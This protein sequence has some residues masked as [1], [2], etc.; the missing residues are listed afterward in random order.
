LLGEVP[1]VGDAMTRKL[2]LMFL[3]AALCWMIPLANAGAR[4]DQD[5]KDFFG[6]VTLGLTL[7]QGDFG[8]IADDDLA[9]GAGFTYWPQDWVVGLNVDVTYTDMD[10]QN[11]VIRRI[12]EA[13]AGMGAGSIS[14]GDISIWSLSTNALWGPDTS[15]NVG[16]YVTG[17]VGIDFLDGRIKDDALVYYPPVC[18]PWFWWCIPGGVGPGSVVVL[19]EDTTEFAW[20]AGIGVTFDIRSGGQFFIEARYK[21][22][23]TDRRS[24]EYVPLVVGFRW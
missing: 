14:G 23:E 19:S 20:N 7:P 9:I 2:T 16:F 12:N 6:H 15:G 17:G 24:T 1:V 10:L 8:D 21:T 3:V 11:S 4:P 13:L 22:A 18:D 5:W